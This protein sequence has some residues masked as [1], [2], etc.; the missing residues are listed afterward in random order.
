M[1]GA[2]ST[3]ICPVCDNPYD[4][5]KHLKTRHHLHPACW[6]P[7]AEPIVYVCSSCHGD[8]NHKYPQSKEGKRWSIN[9]CLKKWTIFCR[10]KGKE[11][12]KIY[13][14]LLN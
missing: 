14:S 4:N 5:G 3:Q 1:E 12:G 13:P 9:E 7:R 8:F 11:V 6:Y 2:L 10:S